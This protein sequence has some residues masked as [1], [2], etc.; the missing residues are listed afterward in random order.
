[1]TSEKNNLANLTE[2]A[3]RLRLPAQWLQNEA[4]EGRI[5]CLRIGRKY[6]F[7]V[8]AVKAALAERAAGE[9]AAHAK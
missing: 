5:P 6:R 7:N 3:N 2:L 4:D 1:M 8:D 9:E